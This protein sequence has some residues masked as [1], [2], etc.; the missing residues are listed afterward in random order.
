M[1]PVSDFPEPLSEP[2][3]ETHS[4]DLETS[5]ESHD[6][7]EEITA[8]EESL[9]DIMATPG[10]KV[11]EMSEEEMTEAGEPS[12]IISAPHVSMGKMVFTLNDILITRWPERKQEFHSWLDT[13]KLTKESHYNV[14]VE[15]VSRFTGMLKDWWNSVDQANQL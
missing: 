14:L 5:Y 11:E 15:F 9:P 2:S 13:R 4:E 6:P 10:V 1:T 12:T 3:S 8:T 7:T